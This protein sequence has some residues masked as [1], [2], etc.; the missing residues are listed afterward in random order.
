MTNIYV[1]FLAGGESSRIKKT[2]NINFHKSC[3]PIVK[4][5]TL[6]ELNIDTYKDSKELNIK[7]YIFLLKNDY[8]SIINELKDVKYKNIYPII[9]INY[10]FFNMGKGGAVL[11]AL[12]NYN[13]K[14]DDV[15]IIH[16]SD[17][18]FSN[19]NIEGI[20]QSHIN[21]KLDMTILLSKI[22]SKTNFTEFYITEDLVEIRKPDIK[23]V[24]VHTGLTLVSGNLIKKELEHFNILSMPF[25]L[26][27]KWFNKYASES[28][29]NFE[30]IE[31]REW[32]SV[33][34]NEEYT[35]LINY[36]KLKA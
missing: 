15:F 17:D 5:K 14:D 7:E 6:I 36:Y 10:E 13:I 25:D 2:N 3:L 23:E 31:K 24:N 22:K 20:I 28:S 8:E 1:L 9:K 16:N 11:N 35:E 33:N 4:D 19:L 26:E 30:F 27:N 34:N 32:F 29:I 12:K 21:S 18:Y